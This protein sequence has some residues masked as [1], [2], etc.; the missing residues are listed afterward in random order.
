M[1]NKSSFI[2]WMQQKI[3]VLGGVCVLGQ[4]NL[5]Q[6]MNFVFE[7]IKVTMITIVRLQDT[8]LFKKKTKYRS[9]IS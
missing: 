6:T 3:D 2:P 1:F 8:F 4:R 7:K 5:F 9:A